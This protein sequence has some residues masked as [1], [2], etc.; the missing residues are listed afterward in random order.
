M[1]LNDR[2]VRASNLKIALPA[3]SGL[4][5]FRDFGAQFGRDLRNRETIRR[6]PDHFRGRPAVEHLAERAGVLHNAIETDDDDSRIDP[7][8]QL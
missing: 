2:P 7:V 5:L 1:H 3:T 8:E 6:V 4:Q